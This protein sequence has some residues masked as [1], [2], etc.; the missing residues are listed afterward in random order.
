[1][2]N[3]G[4]AMVKSPGFKGLEI[5]TTVPTAAEARCLPRGAV[6][7]DAHGGVTFSD[8]VAEVL[9]RRSHRGWRE[10]DIDETSWTVIELNR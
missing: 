8:A 4:S 1:M 7:G 10:I 5:I 2:S 9:E 6:V 3:P